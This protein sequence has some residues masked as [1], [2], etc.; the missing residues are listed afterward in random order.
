MK[1]GAFR[2]VMAE[3]PRFRGTPPYVRTTAG[4]GTPACS[5]ILLISPSTTVD[6]WDAD[7]S[8]RSQGNMI[9][10]AFL[11]QRVPILPA[12]APSHVG[13]DQRRVPFSEVFDLPRLAAAVHM[14]I[15]EWDDLKDTN[16]VVDD[17]L[18][19]WSN[20]A[21]A[22]KTQPRHSWM[23]ERM[24]VG[25]RWRALSTSCSPADTTPCADISYTPVPDWA[26]LGDQDHANFF[27]LAKLSN[28]D[29]RQQSL[30]TPQPSH[31]LGATLHPDHQMLCFDVPYFISADEPW[32]YERDYSPVWHTVMKH[33]H[34]TP[35]LEAFADEYLRTTFQLSSDASIPPVS[36][37]YPPAI[38]HASQASLN[39]LPCYSS[40]PFTR[41]TATLAVSALVCPRTS[42][43]P[44]SACGGSTSTNCA[45]SCAP[46][47]AS[48]WRTSS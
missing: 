35:R 48:R 15:I 30:G 10:L 36:L 26:V 24:H 43:L 47:R 4:D 41:A 44:R 37:A 13:W 38:S 39:A 20:W 31:V 42:A 12:F 45:K 18:G 25:E 19:C 21:T 6:D 11:T 14:P 5:R 34:F 8:L 22:S 32:E 1:L 23:T 16:S 2:L 7:T 27:K 17:T 3:T 9:Y 40:S 29:V 46:R 33:A 28:P